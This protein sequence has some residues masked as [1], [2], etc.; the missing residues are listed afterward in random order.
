MHW[1]LP[2]GET[3]QYFVLQQS[4]LC[5]DVHKTPPCRETSLS[6]S[7]GNC[8]AL[9]WVISLVTLFSLASLETIFTLGV[10]PTHSQGHFCGSL[11]TGS[12]QRLFVV[13][14]SLRNYTFAVVPCGE[15]FSL[16]KISPPDVDGAPPPGRLRHQ[17]VSS[18]FTRPAP[19]RRRQPPGR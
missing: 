6:C 4:I 5:S 8:I 13:L 11:F 12:M 9:E 1:G 14:F 18:S 17:T 10:T 2:G 16:C 7:L 15:N 19:S 3:I